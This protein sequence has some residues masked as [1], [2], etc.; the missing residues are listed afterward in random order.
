MRRVT[1]FI[2]ALCLALGAAACGKKGPLD[3]PQRDEQ[4]EQKSTAGAPR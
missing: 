4:D 1:V 3:K 2:L